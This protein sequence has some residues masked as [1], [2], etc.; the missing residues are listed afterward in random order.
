MPGFGLAA[1]I[2]AQLATVR[3]PGGLGFGPAIVI[4]TLPSVVDRQIDRSA[5]HGPRNAATPGASCWTAP[6]ASEPGTG[7]R[8]G[9]SCPDNKARGT[10]TCLLIALLA[11][12]VIALLAMVAFGPISVAEAEEFNVIVVALVPLVTAAIVHYSGSEGSGD[13]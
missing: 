9:S 4:K 11:L 5:R 8:E 7:C 6:T 10:I 12:T 3:L 13:E 2:R 1:P